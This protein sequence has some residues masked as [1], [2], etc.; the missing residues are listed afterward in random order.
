MGV[1]H[2][3]VDQFRLIAGVTVHMGHALFE[4]DSAVDLRLAEHLGKAECQDACQ[5]TDEHAPD[6]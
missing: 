3:L 5:Q 6:E 1:L 2:L 4:G